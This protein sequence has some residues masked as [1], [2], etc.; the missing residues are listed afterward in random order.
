MLHIQD[1][2]DRFKEMQ[3]K[4]PFEKVDVIFCDGIILPRLE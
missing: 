2:L 4:E 3:S 1:Y